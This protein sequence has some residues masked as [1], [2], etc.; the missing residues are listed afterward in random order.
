MRRTRLPLVLVLVFGAMAGCATVPDSSPVQV[1]RQIGNGDET[2][3]PAREI[4]GKEPLDLVREFVSRAGSPVDKHGEAR[5]YLTPE[6]QTWDDTADLTVLDGQIDTVPAPGAADPSTNATTIRIRGMKIGRLLTASGTFEPDQATFVVDVDVVKRNGQWRISGLPAGVVLS[7]GSFF[8]NYRPVPIWFVDPVSR[9][10][11]PDLR[12]V[13]WVPAK[14]QAAR[15]IDLL[16]A[17]PSGALKGA[18]VSELP[19]FSTPRS[20]VSA[21]ADG[22]LVVDLAKVG[23]LDVPSRRLLAAQVVLSMAEVN[24]SKVRLLADGEPL[25]PGG[26]KDWGREDIQGLSAET[27]TPA[28]VPAIVAS[29]GRIQQLSGTSPTPLPGPFGTGSHVAESAAYS[30]DGR[31]LAVVAKSGAGRILLLNGGT[32]TGVVP[33]PLS[34]RTM[35]RPTWNP[36]GTEVMTVLD[37]SSIARV[38]LDQAGNYRTGKVNDEELASRGP[39]RDLRLSRDGM[40]VVAVVGGGLYTAAVARSHD[41]EVAIRNVRRL[42]PTEL[43]EVVAA[44]WRASGSIAVITRNPTMP[45]VQITVD[46]L[47]LKPV[48]GNNLTPPLTAVAAS[49]NRPLLVTDQTGIWSFGGGEADAWRQMLGAP[50]DAVPAYPG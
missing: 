48:I 40:R 24:V 43:G 8:E 41:G 12:Y 13:P 34:A 11:V 31:V 37:S 5:R 32:E 7:L 23:D 25:I 50:A 6:A 17:G 46:G 3:P 22:V 14:T 9:R 26:Q 33:V 47:D 44:D 36:N 1:L 30:A 18:A 39:I 35:T 38:T 49:P 28:T 27:A 4:N 29:G 20:N 16:L 2:L 10:V 15:V 19:A 21:G 45:V 42:R